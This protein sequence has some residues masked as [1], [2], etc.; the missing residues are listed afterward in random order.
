MPGGPVCSQTAHDKNVL[1]SMRAVRDRPA[2]P[3]GWETPAT[4]WRRDE[5]QSCARRP[6]TRSVMALEGGALTRFLI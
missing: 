6:R 2:S 1:G 5:E 3:A 4:E